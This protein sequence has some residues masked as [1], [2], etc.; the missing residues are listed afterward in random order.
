[1]SHIILLLYLVSGVSGIISAAYLIIKYGNKTAFMKGY[2]RVHLTYTFLMLSA[3]VVLYLKVNVINSSNVISVFIALIIL[4]QGILCMALSELSF[5]INDKG[6][7]NKLRLF[8]KIVPILFVL[9]AILQ[10]LLWNTAFTL[11]PIIIAVPS[12]ILISIWFTLRNNKADDI[13]D[14]KERRIWFLFL[15]FTLIIVA[16]EITLKY[17]FGF[18]GEDTI[19]I[20]VIFMCWNFL[21]MSQ[22]QNKFNKPQINTDISNEQKLKW[23]LTDREVE[24]SQAIL[25]GDSNKEIASN[26][27]ISYSTVKNHI[28]NIYG[29]TGAKSRV[30]LVNIFK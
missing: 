13:Q 23:Q 11:Y 29:K 14:Y 17:L 3:L 10:L 30:D 21:S 28:Y 18:L 24:V 12:F 27:H 2:I 15:L 20:P 26:L 6:I 1:M 8:W 4:G 25:R 9:L 16:I 22:F 7:T 19:N 5:V